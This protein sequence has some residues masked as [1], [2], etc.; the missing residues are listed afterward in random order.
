MRHY[1]SPLTREYRRTATSRSLFLLHRRR[2]YSVAGR[3][4]SL[5]GPR[6]RFLTRMC[7][8]TPTSRSGQY[9]V[10]VPRARRPLAPDRTSRSR[11]KCTTLASRRRSGTTATPATPSVRSVTPTRPTGGAAFL[12]LSGQ[13][14]SGPAGGAPDGY[15]LGRGAAGP[16]GATSAAAELCTGRRVDRTGL[17]R[18]ASQ[19]VTIQMSAH[20][21]P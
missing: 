13:S 7:F 6:G 10:G 18:V 11:L 9:Q 2:S 16:R 12:F 4:F 1:Q 14:P 17:L 5:A 20:A 8:Q 21:P 3:D 19:D 15:G